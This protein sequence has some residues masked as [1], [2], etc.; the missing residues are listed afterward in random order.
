MCPHNFSNENVSRIPHLL[1][2][3]CKRINIWIVSKL[4]LLKI[5]QRIYP[6]IIV[7][8]FTHTLCC[9]EYVIILLMM[10]CG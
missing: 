6:A 9:C 3:V 1:E 4:I 2:K 10:K 8:R 7:H 5:V